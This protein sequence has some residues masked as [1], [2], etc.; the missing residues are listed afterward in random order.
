MGNG[1]HTG[2]RTTIKHL[3]EHTDIIEGLHFQLDIVLNSIP[4]E[5]TSVRPS[6]T[7]SVI[8]AQAQTNPQEV[9]LATAYD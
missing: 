6:M 8:Q 9:Y 3:D 1:R 5:F 2:V 4:V 7:S